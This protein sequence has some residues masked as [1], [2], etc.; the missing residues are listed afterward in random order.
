MADLAL[1]VRPNPPQ[2]QRTLD[3]ERVARDLERLNVGEVRF[4]DHDRQLYSTDASLYQVMPIGI[5]VPH[6]TDNVPAIVNYAAAH[7]LALLPRGGGTSL[8][9]QCTNA[10]IVLDLSPTCR[11]IIGIDPNQ[12]TATVEPGIGVD[13]F[14]RDLLVRNI[15][16]FFAPDPATSNQCAIGGCIG[17]NAAGARS[18]RYGRTS[19]NIASVEVV[20]TT[21]ER[22]W[23]EPGAGRRSPVALR[24]AEQVADVVR[25][26]A[27]EIRKRF[28]KLIR[29]N[30]G[31]ELDPIL[32]QLERG[33]TPEDLDLS[34]LICGS[35]GTLAIVTQ[36]KLMLQPMPLARGLAVVSF[37][38]VEHAIDA[39]VAIVGTQPSAVELL[40]DAV[41]R[42]ALG[43]TECR[44]YV[45]MLPRVA[46]QTPQ[47][48]LYVE[49]QLENEG[50]TLTACFDRMRAVLSDVSIAT[51]E[52]P[53]AMAN[54][55]GLRKSS[56]ALLHGLP[57]HAKPITF[58]EDN[59]VPVENLKRFVDGF[60]QI[61]TKHNTIAAYYAHASVGVLHVRPMIDLHAP[62]EREKTRAIAVEVAQL[63]R[64]CGGVMSGEHGDGRVRGP[65]LESL[66]GPVITAA[67]KRIKNIF[68]PAGIL[69]PGNIVDAGPIQSITENLRLDAQRDPFKINAIDTYFEYPHDEGFN[70]AVELCNGAGFC[71][72]TA[73]GVMC[74]SYRATLDERHS[75]RGRANAVRVAVT[76]HD[77]PDWADADVKDTLNLCLSCKACKTE[78]PSNVDIAQLKA[79]YYAQSYRAQ[80]GSPL[81]AKIVG[82]VR[83]LNRLASIAPGVANAVANFAPVRAISNKV[84]NLHPKRSL[85]PFAK[86]LYRWFGKRP[87]KPSTAAPRVALW[88]DCFMTYSEPNIGI[89]ATKAL[90][91][92]GYAVDLPPGGCCGRPMMSTGLLA[93]AIATADRTLEIF[94]PV[95]EDDNVRAII[96]FEPSCLSAIQDEWLKLKLK[97]PRLL[98]EKLARKAMLIEQFVESNWEAHPTRPAIAADTTDIILHGHCHQKALWGETTTLAMLRRLTGG[99][100]TAIPSTCC[101]MA[102]AFGY[103]KDRY[104]LSMRIGELSVFPAV[105]A[106]GD[107]TTLCVPGT[108]CRHQIHDGTGRKSL[109]PAEVLAKALGV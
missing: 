25:D 55:W 95:I 18:I 56:E 2:G 46:G 83:K 31:Y 67:F 90:E 94:R 48:V 105:R 99:R 61:V 109:H 57:G 69:N 54:A 71:R 9:G 52:D 78:C 88:P 80:G 3:V 20:L 64:D 51:Y 8:A 72:K 65:L 4:G 47:A 102:G 34:K 82:H 19:E 58:V 5:V 77:Q 108:S 75:T 27:D 106:A 24:L 84:M 38:S 22:V 92:F 39:V 103:T 74:P 11:R 30:A 43:N 49:Y 37:A 13:E 35:E 12:R 1:P 89:A 70:G 16:L 50:E 85:P 76:N 32:D 28:P 66:Y 45:D 104:D 63:A 23:L 21:G 44:K 98:R 62:G 68:D 100:V 86:S 10:A 107:Q 101:G 81:Q 42:A 79:E 15:P 91:A 17:N 29:R 59:S 41:I 7:K 40:D 6:S 73:V 97:T 93:D 60:K 36:A 33:V 26:N 87:T 53:L 14:N 96:V